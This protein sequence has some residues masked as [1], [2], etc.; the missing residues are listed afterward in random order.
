MILKNE[1]IEPF[2]EYVIMSCG[3]RR[4]PKRSR[5]AD[6]QGLFRHKTVN[7]SPQEYTLT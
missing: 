3:W 2:K 6:T 1:S 7:K 4:E 5:Y